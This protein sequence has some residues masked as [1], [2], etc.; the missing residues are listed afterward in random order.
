MSIP[1]DLL[2]FLSEPANREMTLPEGEVRRLTLFAPDE[3][4]PQKF[5][6]NSSELHLNGPLETDPEEQR[7]YEGYP[8]VRKCNDY[9]PEGVLVWFPEFN[10]Y[11]SADTGHERIIIYPGI[12]WSDIIRESTWYINGQWYPERVAHQEVNPWFDSK[13]G[14]MPDLSCHYLSGEEIH[15]GDRAKLGGLPGRVMF[16]LGFE[17]FLP[18]WAGNREWFL[19]KFGSGFMWEQDGG[20]QV[21]QQ[22]ADE[23][24]EFVSRGENFGV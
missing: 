24:F 15:A 18:E 21:F 1:Q 17:D 20:G 4:K 19:Q 9:L 11:G 8:L 6:V 23:D 5:I 12:I 16:V 7:E 14:V 2:N 10:A 13:S 22:K 3:L